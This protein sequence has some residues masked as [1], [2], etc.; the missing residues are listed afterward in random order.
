MF[1]SN[2]FNELIFVLEVTFGGQLSVFV[3]EMHVMSV[4][5]TIMQCIT[6]GDIYNF[7]RPRAGPGIA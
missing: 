7:L 5:Y 4:G 6:T 1:R 2:T 3:C